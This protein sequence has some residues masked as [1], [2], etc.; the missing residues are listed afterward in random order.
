MAHTRLRGAR[1]SADRSRIAREHARVGVDA[2]QPFRQST[3]VAQRPTFCFGTM[4]VSAS[5]GAG[6]HI[7]ADIHV[8]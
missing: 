1:G 8:I 7:A 2:Q 5:L 4:I 3:I 6:T